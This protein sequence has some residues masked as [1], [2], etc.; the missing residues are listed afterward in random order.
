MNQTGNVEGRKT[1][2]QPPEEASGLLGCW[3]GGSSIRLSKVWD[4]SPVGWKY[5][6][7]GLSL[8]HVSSLFWTSFCDFVNV[9]F[10]DLLLFV[11]DALL[12]LL[13]CTVT[14][15]T[16]LE[17]GGSPPFGLRFQ[18]PW[19]LDHLGSVIQSLR[20][21]GRL[22]WCPQW[23]GHYWRWRGSRVWRRRIS[24]TMKW[25]I[26]VAKTSCS[27]RAAD[28]WEQS[29]ELR[30]YGK[31]SAPTSLGAEWSQSRWFSHLTRLVPGT[32]PWIS[33]G[34]V[35]LG[36]DPGPTQNTLERW[37]ILFSQGM[38]RDASGS[39]RRRGGGRLG[40]LAWFPRD[41]NENM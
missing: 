29:E 2:A 16:L 30:E 17:N 6:V 8:S 15:V 14:T 37:N 9:W 39:G 4:R 27:R 10:G 19:G 18:V 25:R 20:S 3:K 32:P 41:P 35:Q 12:L 13:H 7:L 26:R 24:E 22:V 38:P 40:Y 23:C 31:S 28:S 34:H 1:K 11:D 33:S 21:T 5:G 36:S